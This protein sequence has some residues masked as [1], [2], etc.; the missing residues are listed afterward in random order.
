[1]GGGS[2][3]T[4]AQAVAGP[5]VAATAAIARPLAKRAQR[6]SAAETGGN[7]GNS[8]TP[9]AGP[10]G[11]P[12]SKHHL[13]H[14]DVNQALERKLLPQ[15]GGS[16]PSCVQAFIDGNGEIGDEDGDDSDEDGVDND[17]QGFKDAV[18]WLKL[19]LA[20]A[21]K[22]KKVKDAALLLLGCS[23]FVCN[24]EYTGDF[25][26]LQDY[27]RKL[28]NKIGAPLHAYYAQNGL[29]ALLGQL[30]LPTIASQYTLRQDLAGI[31]DFLWISRFRPT[32][33]IS[34]SGSKTNPS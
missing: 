4:K 29:A 12:R 11:T 31:V 13:D 34:G 16:P 10:S 24:L 3:K 30:H 26:E 2:S 32:T 9:S 19:A 14:N 20:G 22:S 33:M 21:H 5:A 15:A 18:A 25:E 1:M 7:G 8:G 27:C 6:R 28:L 17:R 23:N